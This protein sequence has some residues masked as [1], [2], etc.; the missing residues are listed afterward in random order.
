[1]AKAKGDKISQLKTMK[2]YVALAIV[3]AKKYQK[4]NI[5]IIEEMIKSNLPGVYVTLNRPY[6]NIK[7]I[8]EKEKIDTSKVIFIDS[9]TETVS[10]KVKKRDDCL[11]IG[12]PKN[13]SDLSLAMD[14]AIMAIP[15]KDKFLFFDSLSTLALYHDI[16]VVAKF[17][18]FLSGKM[19]VWKIKG[20]II[21]L[22][23]DKD[24]E[25]IDELNSFCDL[26]IDF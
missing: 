4:T 21:S 1:M 6:E 19:R 14:Q 5:K 13:L 22:R 15:K 26:T 18:H 24:K 10:G 16:N 8:F 3:D 9:V 11:F 20:I 17:I 12:G 7:A 25:L 2:D 23:R